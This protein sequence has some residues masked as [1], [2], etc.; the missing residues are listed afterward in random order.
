[1]IMMAATVS[2]VSPAHLEY[3]PIAASARFDENGLTPLHIACFNKNV[4]PGIIRLLIDAAPDSI[5]RVT[6]KG[7]MPLHILCRNSK[8]DEANAIQILT[9]LIKKSPEAVRLGDNNGFLP[10]TLRVEGDLLIFVVCLL[11]HILDLSE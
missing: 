9:L 3:F 7:H 6:K 2:S 11:K 10:F 8:V 1:M 5:R 4:T